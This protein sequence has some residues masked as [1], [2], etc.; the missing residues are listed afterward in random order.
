MREIK[1]RAWHKEQKQMYWFDVMWGNYSQG[2]GYIGM[3]ELG[4]PRESDSSY[5]GNQRFID[6]H[7][8]VLLQYTGF[9]SEWFAWETTTDEETNIY[10]NQII[11]VT[12]LNDILPTMCYVCMSKGR[13]ICKSLKEEGKQESLYRVLSHLEY[14]LHKTHEIVED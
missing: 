14:S 7:D 4:K 8:C 2:S 1:Y 5:N 3:V 9:D 13:W 10:E 12:F 6:P 11:E